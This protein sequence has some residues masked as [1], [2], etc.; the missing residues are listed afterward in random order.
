MNEKNRKRNTTI[1]TIIFIIA[2]VL[3]YAYAFQVTEVNLEE[4]LQPRRQTNLIGLLRELA[5]PDFFDFDEELRSTN[6]SIQMP[7]PEEVD[8]SEATLEGRVVVLSP[9]CATTTQDVLTVTGEGFAPN[10]Q[11]ILRWYP[12]G[13]TTAR[14][15]T[16]FRADAQGN[17]TISFTMPD[18]R[19]T[20]EAQQIE[21][22]EVVGRTLEGFSAASTVTFE[23]II[24]TILMALMASTVGTILAVPIS[25]L[26]A[27]NLMENLKMPLASISAA[28]F[29]IPVGA[30]IGQQIA[31]ALVNISAQLTENALV[32]LVVLVVVAAVL[33]LTVRLGPS[34]VGNGGS[35][36]GGAIFGVIVVIVA[37]FVVFFGLG[38][39]AHLGI[40]AGQWLDPRLGIFGFLGNFIFVMA[41]FTQLL[42]PYTLGLI[43][44]LAAASLGGRFARG[45]VFRFG[46]G[47]GLLVTFILTF[48]GFG[49]LVF[50]LIY[51]FNWICLVGLCRQLPQEQSALL[52]TLAIPAVIGG[53]LAGIVSL[54]RD[55]EKPFSIGF[56]IYTLSRTTLNL[57]RAIEPLIMGAVF[58]VWVGI[59]PFAGIMAL[60]LHSIADLGKLFS[61][62]VENIEEGPLEAVTAT[63]AN[64][65]QVIVF[66]VIPQITPHYIAFAFYRWDINV[67]MSTIIGFI[68]GGGIG[69]VLQRSANLTQYSQA[70]VMIIAIAVVV[71]A[72]DYISSRLRSRII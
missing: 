60:I 65:L 61:E 7:C 37:L 62:Q 44:A 21:V 31:A 5:R 70:S 35:R 51:A 69:L 39:V 30:V 50:L 32:G 19:P 14:S 38:L 12:L 40:Q 36:S 57:L 2:G 23:R 41:G 66:S 16:P 1:R 53:G 52:Q 13:T 15:L 28:L 6:V 4:P 29:L 18:I 55:P 34:L 42:L 68:G 9:N 24:E 27:R 58:V 71:A 56:L 33:P 43:G 46:P 64:S 72:L 22:V 3:L 17:F 59:G 67:R 25:F 49:A 10:V 26:A 45:L 54:L 11:G 8:S 47:S 63:G 20:E 48:L